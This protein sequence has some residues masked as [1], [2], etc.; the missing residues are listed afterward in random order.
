MNSREEHRETLGLTG[1]TEADSVEVVM[2]ADEEWKQSRFES[3]C[4]CPSV[5]TFC[6]IIAL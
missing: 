5:A 2:L 1:E 3:L 4:R 6:L